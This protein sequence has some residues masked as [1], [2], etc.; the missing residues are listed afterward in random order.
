VLE[1]VEKVCSH[2]TILHNGRQLA[3]GSIEDLKNFQQQRSLEGA[4]ASL[5]QEVDVVQ[6]ARAMVDAVMS[7]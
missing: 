5:V 2:V 6:T 3:Y 4:F 1:V 7:Q